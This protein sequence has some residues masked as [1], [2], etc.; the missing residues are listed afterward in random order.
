MHLSLFMSTF[1]G[2]KRQTETGSTENDSPENQ[3]RVYS[4]V[5]NT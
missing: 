1:T 4:A 2:R 5:A 3:A